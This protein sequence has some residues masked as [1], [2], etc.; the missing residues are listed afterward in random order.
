MNPT[1]VLASA[2]AEGRAEAQVK[3]VTLTVETAEG[4]LEFTL[5]R[6]G[7]GYVKLQGASDRHMW[8]PDDREAA[9]IEELIRGWLE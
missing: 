1:L 3:K 5:Y 4:V 8:I 9:G 2:V 6:K 7:V